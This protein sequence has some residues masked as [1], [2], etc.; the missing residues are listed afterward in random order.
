MLVVV[1]GRLMPGVR[2]ARL[3]RSRV[4]ER[5]YEQVPRV[6]VLAFARGGFGAPRT[7]GV[8]LTSDRIE[9]PQPSAGAAA[10]RVTAAARRNRRLSAAH[11][12]VKLRRLGLRDETG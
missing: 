11:G 1:C 6:G 8:T 7:P 9:A 2:R 3:A 10:V 5:C 12:G 4:E